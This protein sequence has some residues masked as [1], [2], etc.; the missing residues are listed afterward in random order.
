M[1]ALG[2]A[3]RFLAERSTCDGDGD[4]SIDNGAVSEA[5][6]GAG[7]AVREGCGT[8]ALT[9]VEGRTKLGNGRFLSS[10]DNA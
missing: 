4:A 9:E 10:S 1:V 7:G 8:R 5:G 2:N 3:P 6:A